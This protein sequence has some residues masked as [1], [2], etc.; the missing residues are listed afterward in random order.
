MSIEQFVT[1]VLLVIK[2]QL[3]TGMVLFLYFNL[4]SQ[5]GILMQ[6]LLSCETTTDS[7]ALQ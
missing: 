2:L 1:K 5:A 6:K 7:V 3:I 4:D